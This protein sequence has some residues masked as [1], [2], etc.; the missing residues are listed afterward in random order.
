MFQGDN[1][2]TSLGLSM[3]VF[4][5]WR[6]PCQL[7]VGH[8]TAS[9]LLL[10]AHLQ[11]SASSLA[12][13]PWQTWVRIILHI[14]FRG[15]CHRPSIC[16]GSRILQFVKNNHGCPLKWDC[17]CDTGSKFKTIPNSQ[18]QLSYGYIYIWTWSNSLKPKYVKRKCLL[19]AD[20]NNTL[21]I[22]IIMGIVRNENDFST[23]LILC[24]TRMTLCCRSL[25]WS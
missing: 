6:G 12:S 4:R 25:N 7:I 19:S 17:I 10:N 18:N 20:F 16:Q 21:S 23:I 15:S 5:L 24:V 22:C 14:P 3:R 11:G 13:L 2:H 9:S 1:P 8:T